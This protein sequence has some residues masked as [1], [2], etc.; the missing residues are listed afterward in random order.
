MTTTFIGE[1]PVRLAFA[2]TIAAVLLAA[3]GGGGQQGSDSAAGSVAGSGRVELTGA[4]ATFPYPIYSKWIHEYDRQKGVRINYQSI[5][6]GGG[7]RQLSEGT[8]DFGASDSPMTDEEISRAKGGAVLHVPTVLGAVVLTYNLPGVA[9]P[10]KLTS[11]AIADIYL[12][13]I[14]KWND[15]RITALNPG[16]SLPNADI[17][18]VHRSDGSGTSFVFTDYL[19]SVSQDWSR[20]PGRGKEVQWP[21][22]LGGKGNEGVAGQVK[23]TP[24]AIGYVELAYARQNRLPAAAVRNSSGNF[25]EPAIGSI[26]AAAA[27]A[28]ATLPPTT[29]FR[30]SIVNPTGADAY[31]I[32]SFTWILLYREQ[33]NADKGRKLVDFLR[34]AI[35]DGQAMAPPLDYAPLPDALVPMLEA[36]LDSVRIGT[37][38]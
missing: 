21:V 33:P 20:G 26:T 10:L 18:V 37:T 28:M 14:V 34:W 36:R 38:T 27:G 16:V 8:V 13:R 25:V 12:G 32:A 7:I 23:Q 22:G 35:R 31:P 11:D 5:G 15:T 17:I 19:A 29:D 1:R 9:Q 3:C 24:N 2:A 6:S 30:V 4:G